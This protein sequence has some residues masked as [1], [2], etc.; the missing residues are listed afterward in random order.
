MRCANFC[1]VQRSHSNFT[2]ILC[3]LAILSHVPHV[4]EEQETGGSVGKSTVKMGDGI[5]EVRFNMQILRT[6]DHCISLFFR[7]FF[8]R[9]ISPFNISFPDC[10]ELLKYA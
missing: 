4:G 10:V 3:V 2:V 1:G 7:F 8:S 6:D 5:S 9:L